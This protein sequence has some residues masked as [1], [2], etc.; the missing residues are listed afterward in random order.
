M[1][2]FFASA[3]QPSAVRFSEP[4]F[5]LPP[6][7]NDAGLE[8]PAGARLGPPATA[9][10]LL[11][12]ACAAD[13]PALPSSGGVLCVPDQ[14]LMN[15]L[16]FGVD[17][18]LQLRHSRPY[19]WYI[20]RLTVTGL[21]EASHR[22][23]RVDPHS[24]HAEQLLLHIGVL[25]S[26]TSGRSLAHPLQKV[27]PLWHVVVG[28]QPRPLFGRVS[29]EQCLACRHRPLKQVF[30]PEAL[31]QAPTAPAAHWTLHALLH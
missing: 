28:Y 29:G 30:D 18:N 11:G 16:C 12:P 15:W 10:R 14:L 24:R 23:R 17:T 31:G 1:N 8:S 25:I 27:P 13:L 4:T 9:G 6:A 20:S 2:A 19:R 5:A 21:A 3:A 26:L 7:C 22:P